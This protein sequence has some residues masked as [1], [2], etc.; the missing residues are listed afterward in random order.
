MIEVS[1]DVPG[2][3]K[4]PG[5]WSGFPGVRDRNPFVRSPGSPHRVIF[6]RLIVPSFRYVSFSMHTRRSYQLG[7]CTW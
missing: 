4:V 3:S 1:K 6:T 2:T 7:P 5:T